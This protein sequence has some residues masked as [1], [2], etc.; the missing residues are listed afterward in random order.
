MLKGMRGCK[1]GN[2]RKG[3]EEQERVGEKQERGDRE[4]SGI[5]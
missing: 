3:E 2:R 4:G 1:E 5:Q